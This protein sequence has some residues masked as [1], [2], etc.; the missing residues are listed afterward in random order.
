MGARSGKNY[1]KRCIELCLEQGRLL[2]SFDIQSGIDV[3]HEH[4]KGF[5]GA[6]M[7]P[8]S[9]GNH[10]HASNRIDNQ[11]LESVVVLHFLYIDPA[12][13]HGLGDGG[14]GKTGFGDQHCVRGEENED[15][16]Y[17]EEKDYASIFG[18]DR[19]AEEKRHTSEG[20]RK[21]HMFQFATQT[22]FHG[23]I[24]SSFRYC[25]TDGS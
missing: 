2:D 11:K 18:G 13:E 25:T 7:N 17:N 21:P 1:I 22:F 6:G 3:V 8:D 20:Y 14:Y 23:S 4:V 24:P 10:R 5:R 19:E 9:E 15:D 12:N 16:G